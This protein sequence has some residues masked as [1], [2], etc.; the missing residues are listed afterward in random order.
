VITIITV[1]RNNAAGLKKTIESVVNQS[2]GAFEFIVIDGDST[3]GSKQ[4]MDH[5]K[6]RLTIALSEPDTGIYN[7]M[8]KAIKLAK[9]DYVLFL[10]SGDYLL[11]EHVLKTV[12]PRLTGYD[13]ISGDII[14]EENNKTYERASKDEITLDFFFRI[15]LYHQATFI[16]KK[17]FDQYG[18]YNETFKIGGDYEFFIRVFYK[19]NA[20]YLH[21]HEPVSYFKA[22]GISNNPEFLTIKNEEA[23]TAWKLN[24][25]ER[26]YQ[27][28]TEHQQFE[29]SPTYW[30]YHKAQTSMLYKGFFTWINRV[31][32]KVY[33]L[34]RK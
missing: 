30:L 23:L 27:I 5:Y 3:D 21:I 1:N 13:V 33:R 29:N 20:S 10:N 12:A 8:N 15:S 19:Y 4:V 31:R 16:A 34:F 14:L 24:V 7:A 25:S 17:L 9:G 11:N 26:M 32:N 6:G 2:S 22:D 28:L 18:L